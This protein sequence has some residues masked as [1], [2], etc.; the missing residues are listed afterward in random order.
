MVTLLRI[1]FDLFDD[2][3]ELAIG[4]NDNEFSSTDLLTSTATLTLSRSCD[5][6]PRV[7]SVYLDN[8]DQYKARLRLDATRMPR[9]SHALM[10]S[11]LKVRPRTMPKRTHRYIHAP[12]KETSR[13][14][15]LAGYKICKLHKAIEEIS[16]SCPLCASIDHPL[17]S[18]KASLSHEDQRFNEHLQADFVWVEIRKTKYVVLQAVDTGTG[19]SETT[20]VRARN[21]TGTVAGIERIWVNRHGAPKTFASDYEFNTKDMNSLLALHSIRNFHD[22]SVDTIRLES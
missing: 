17:L 18:K 15:R 12:E 3:S 20:I 14:L 7:F 16:T 2:E 19:F 8:R 6:F 13:I 5:D 11:R 4:L 21:T 9:I 1:S 22:Q 10:A